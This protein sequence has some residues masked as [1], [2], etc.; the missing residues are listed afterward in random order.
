MKI[1][2][3]TRLVGIIGDPLD[4]TLSPVIHNAAFDHLG[5]DWCYLP[6]PVREGQ[7]GNALRGIR[8][9]SFAG[10][11]VT[12]PFKTDVIPMLDEVTAFA[13]A[14]GA[15]NTILVENDRLIGY[16]TDG[17]G[18][19]AALEGEIGYD[20]RDKK[21]LVLGAGGAA[22][23]ICVSVALA[24]CRSIMIINRTIKKAEELEKV[25]R[26][27]APGVQVSC[28]SPENNYDIMSAK[29]DVII[30]TTPL[31]DPGGKLGI[32][33]SLL[34][35]NHLVCDI[36]YSLYPAPILQEAEG[37][38]AQVMDGKGMLL[39]QAA[40][41]FEIWTGMQAPVEAMRSALLTAIEGAHA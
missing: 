1:G 24:G 38:G 34:N 14:V 17:R 2:A 29:P 39:Y 25:I 31:T 16:N 20:I 11:N 41:A 3:S 12:M 36:N 4:H 33:V 28:T 21:V 8:A 6:L 7:L 10:V 40:A 5:L 27:S 26:R 32:P 37:N 19:C 23:S 30:N 13:G 22:R 9:L 35:G 18:F 15:V